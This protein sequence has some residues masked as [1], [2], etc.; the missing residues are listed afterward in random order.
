MTMQ[1]PNQIEQELT[2]AAE[3]AA[4][5]DDLEQLRISALGRKGRV[6]ELMKTLGGMRPDERRAAGPA[7]NRLKDIVA[8]AIE[9]RRAVLEAEAVNERLKEERIDITLPVRPETQGTIHPVSQVTEELIAIFAD[10]GFEVPKG[11]TSKTTSTTS[12]R[13]TCR[14]SI[15][16][17][18][19]TIRSISVKTRTAAKSCCARIPR[20][21]RF[22]R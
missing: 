10:M 12:P 8:E 1:D 3:Q 20:R 15:P 11:R 9:T 4:T 21:F 5:L 14:P 13:S 6:T 19:C 2:A 18:K 16:R 7:F 22:G 17:G